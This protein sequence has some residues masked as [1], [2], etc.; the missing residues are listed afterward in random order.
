MPVTANL[1][2]LLRIILLLCESHVSDSLSTRSFLVPNPAETSSVN[3]QT[4]FRNEKSLPTKRIHYPNSLT[5]Y[6]ANADDTEGIKSTSENIPI[7][8]DVVDDDDT[9]KRR[10]L[11]EIQGLTNT[12]REVQETIKGLAMEYQQR[13]DVDDKTLQ[14]TRDE[15]NNTQTT[16]KLN[17]EAFDKERGKLLTELDTLKSNLD[18]SRS[19]L[20]QKEEELTNQSFMLRNQTDELQLIQQVLITERETNK[21]RIQL[22]NQQIISLQTDKDDSISRLGQFERNLTV[23]T[24]LYENASKE[25]IHLNKRIQ[26]TAN[27]N[28]LSLPIVQQQIS[29][30][31][32]ETRKDWEREKLKLLSSHD[33]ALNQV[34]ESWIHK[35]NDMV[36]KSKRDFILYRANSVRERDIDNQRVQEDLKKQQ[37]IIQSLQ[38]DIT[39]YEEERKSLRRLVSLSVKKLVGTL[40]RRD[41]IPSNSNNNNTKLEIQQQGDEQKKHNNATK[42]KKKEKL[43]KKLVPGM[44][45]SADGVEDVI[46]VGKEEVEDSTIQN[47]QSTETGLDVSNRKEKKRFGKKSKK[48]S[49]SSSSSS[50]NNNGTEDDTM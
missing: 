15:L 38:L 4:F 24:N 47:R 1:L 35:Y 10:V 32:N 34:E 16:L 31:Q 17:A 33:E 11:L 40:L 7:S 45:T 46:K 2:T 29:K 14:A 50:S 12:F 25:I 21:Q 3:K 8:G 27:I 41:V 20:F 22:L 49:S 42:D 43:L 9:E 36:E 18:E 44:G 6:T 26:D 39:K 23:Q 30:V 28:I 19:L 13:I 37:S 5:V 48:S